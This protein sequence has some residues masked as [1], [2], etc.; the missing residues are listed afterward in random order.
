MNDKKKLR[1]YFS[2]IRANITDKS[3]KDSLIAKRLLSDVKVINADCIL[4]YASFRSE[5]DT[6]RIAELLLRKNITTAFPKCRENCV[7]TFHMVKKFSELHEGTFGIPEPDISLPKP[8]ITSNTICIV[9][10]LAFTE[11]GGRLGYG[12]G[13]YDRFFAENPDIY[14]IAPAYESLIAE[15]LPLMKHDLTVNEIITEERTVFCN[16]E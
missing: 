13:F 2:E 12:G 7:M 6:R 4:L 5:I 8:I 9:P 3:I 14:K 1:A 15:E 11:K 10:G 16:A